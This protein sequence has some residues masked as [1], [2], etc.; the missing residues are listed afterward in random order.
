MKN[1]S[2][3]AIILSGLFALGTAYTSTSVASSSGGISLSYS[4]PCQGC[5]NWTVNRFL[6][7]SV[8]KLQPPVSVTPPTQIVGQVLPRSKSLPQSAI[9]RFP[10]RPMDGQWRRGL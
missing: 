10:A 8:A 1:V 4:T 7:T 6:S 2:I 9:K 5:I 3:R